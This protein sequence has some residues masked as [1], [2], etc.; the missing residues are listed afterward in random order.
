MTD[1]PNWLN[2]TGQ[3]ADYVA[4]MSEQDDVARPDH[5]PAIEAVVHSFAADHGGDLDKAV[6]MHGAV[7]VVQVRAHLGERP[8][9]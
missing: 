1:W 2:S 9:R 3:P 4:P 6:R 7:V 5:I 8:R